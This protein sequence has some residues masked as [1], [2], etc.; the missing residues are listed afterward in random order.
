MDSK[1]E[2]QHLYGELTISGSLKLP[3]A[4]TVEKLVLS[5]P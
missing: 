3:G 2:V 4:A 1:K 5:S